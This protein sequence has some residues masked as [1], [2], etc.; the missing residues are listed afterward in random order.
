M[1]GILDLLVLIG[2]L[3]CGWWACDIHH[4]TSRRNRS[5][6]FL[7]YPVDEPPSNVLSVDGDGASR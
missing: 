6:S 7:P 5:D 4:I 1:R 3:W 2:G